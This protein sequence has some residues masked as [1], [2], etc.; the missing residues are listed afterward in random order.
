MS[1]YRENRYRPDDLRTPNAKSAAA[2]QATA[3]RKSVV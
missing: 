1:I 3:D 2:S